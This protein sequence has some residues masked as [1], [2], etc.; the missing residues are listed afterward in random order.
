[1]GFMDIVSI[2]CHLSVY[3]INFHNKMLMIGENNCVGPE[4]RKHIYFYFAQVIDY[5]AHI[6]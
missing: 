1:M 6:L 5:L 2:L 3:L 4:N